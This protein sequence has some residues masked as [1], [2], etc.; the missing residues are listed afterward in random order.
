MYL[1]KLSR[2]STRLLTKISPSRV[3]LS[4]GIQFCAVFRLE[5]TIKSDNTPHLLR[6]EN[7]FIR[8]KHLIS[9]SFPDTWYNTAKPLDASLSVPKERGVQERWQNKDI[10]A[11]Q[12]YSSR[13]INR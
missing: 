7:S 1:E 13:T 9:V 8:C 3:L 6:G 12:V 4:I 2:L 10:K 11:Y 5:N